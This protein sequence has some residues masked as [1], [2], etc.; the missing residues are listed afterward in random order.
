M[1]RMDGVD[2]VAAAWPGARPLLL[3]RVTALEDAVA[4]LLGG[5][6]G[7]PEREGARREAHRLAGA[8][9]A[10]GV[11]AGSVVARDLEAAFEVVPPQTAAPG[12]TPF[13]SLA[14]RVW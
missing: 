3:E 4:A 1:R 5:A 11:P 2:P 13:R 10:F 12:R 9:G 7:E 14:S 6:L 8:L